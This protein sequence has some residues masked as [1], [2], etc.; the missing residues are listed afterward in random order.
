MPNRRDPDAAG[1]GSAHAAPPAP[2][3]APPSLA[4]LPWE[5]PRSFL[6][7]DEVG[8][9]FESS[10]AVIL[11]V[12]Y[13]ST[14][15]WGS[16]TRRGPGAIIDSSRYIE[17]YD[18][19]FDSEPGHVIGVH[20]LPALELT[21]AGATPAMI[22]L[23]EAYARVAEVCG[24]RFLVMLGGEHSISSPAVLAQ[25]DRHEERLTVLQM[26]AHA[27]LRGEFEGT[28]HSHASAM[29]RVLDRV[30][31]C[32][33]GV[34]GVS[35]EEVD[36]SRSHDGSTLIWADEMSRDDTWMDRAMAAIGPKVYLTFDVDY[37]DPSVMP[38]TGTPEPGG[39]DWYS[40]LRFLKRV[41]AEREVIAADVVELAP[42][43]GLHA[44]DFM[45][46]KLVYK[47]IGYGCQDR[48]T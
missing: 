23:R 21:R 1:R 20:T 6:G 41:F 24:D 26:D 22:E 14:T 42:T 38:S 37:F 4:G 7:F 16:G 18:P 33:V 48:L 43:P 15:S 8:G 28:P 46:A 32:A 34:R 17:L 47:I 44:P 3:G 29:A 30:D 10:G 27:D 12:P 2:P 31:V 5:L 11:P 36:V 25:A 19:E 35:R 13:E 39:G 40:A 9:A 45:V